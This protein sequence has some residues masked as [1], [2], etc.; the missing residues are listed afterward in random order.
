MPQF[1]PEAALE[2]MGKWVAN[3][4]LQY[5]NASCTAPT[6]KTTAKTTAKAT[7]KA[8]DARAELA[9][10]EVQVLALQARAEALRASLD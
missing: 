4:P 2:F 1:K 9:T 5:Y 6:A 10:I 3:K 7:G 8:T